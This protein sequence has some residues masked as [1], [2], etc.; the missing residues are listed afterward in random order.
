[1]T[2]LYGEPDWSE[3]ERQARL[4]RSAPWDEPQE[5][6]DK[7]LNAI[8]AGH[9]SLG[10]P[11]TSLAYVRSEDEKRTYTVRET[12]CTCRATR[13]CYHL[14]AAELYRLWQDKITPPSLFPTPKTIDERLA[15]APQDAPQATITPQDDIVDV[16]TPEPPLE[17]PRAQEKPM[18]TETLPE[19]T[20]ETPEPPPVL[21]ATQLQHYRQT[22]TKQLAALGQKPSTKGDYEQAV[23]SLV[24]LVLA[25]ENF[26][27]ISAKLSELIT[28]RTRSAPA[29]IPEEYLVDIKGKKHVLFAGLLA[30]AHEKGLRTLAADFVSVTS[31]LALARATATFQDGRTFSEAADATPAN[32]GPQVKPHFARMALTRA[33]ARVLRDAL[34]IGAVS[35]EELE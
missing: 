7:A 9:V 23:M 29:P 32:V 1:M 2:E 21:D 10:V 34:N 14:T 8:K 13:P 30:M 19:T 5:R 12:G 27:E 28:A 11:A 31:E 26:P 24:G 17:A 6:L 4:M 16:P 35:A 15:A 33:K 3:L 18:P 22:I 20:L 25:P